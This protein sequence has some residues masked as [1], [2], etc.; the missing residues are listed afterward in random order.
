MC[1]VDFL[2]FGLIGGG[3]DDYFIC[4]LDWFCDKGCDFVFFKFCDFFF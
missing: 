2:D 3:W 1:V 4:V